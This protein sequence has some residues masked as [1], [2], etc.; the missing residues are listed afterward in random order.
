MQERHHKADPA[1]PYA[2]PKCEE[3]ASKGEKLAAQA[4]YQ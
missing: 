3:I 1:L 4:L 2:I